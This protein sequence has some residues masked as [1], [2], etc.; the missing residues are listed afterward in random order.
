MAD[1]LNSLNL[2]SCSF[3][4][5]L[6]ARRRRVDCVFTLPMAWAGLGLG[7]VGQQSLAGVAGVAIEA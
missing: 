7:P 1:Q 6:S 5:T 2:D 3:P 4:F